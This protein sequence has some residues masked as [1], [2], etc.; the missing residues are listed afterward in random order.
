MTRH[1]VGALKAK[2]EK[3]AGAYADAAAAGSLE[4][5]PGF[6]IGE[7]TLDYFARE[8]LVE[9]MKVFSG[10]LHILS[11]V[12]ETVGRQVHAPT[13]DT[14]V[15]ALNLSETL[16]GLP[17]PV[18]Q[19]DHELYAALVDPA[20]LGALKAFQAQ[21]AVW[22]DA[23]R[24][25]TE[26]MLDPEAAVIRR[27]E[28]QAVVRLADEVRLKDKPLRELAAEAALLAAKA[29]R[30]EQTIAFGRRLARAFMVDTPMKA[31]V[32]RKLLNAADLAASLSQDLRPLRHPGLFDQAASR[33]LREG[34][35]R[36]QELQSELTPLS[37]RLKFEFIGQSHE[38]RGHT[39]A[40]R[41]AG[42]FSS[43]W[44]SDAW[45][46]KRRYKSM[47][48]VPGKVKPRAVVADF[49]ALAE[50]AE[51]IGGLAND[52]NLQAVCGPHF[53]G[54]ETPFERLIEVN[55]YATLVRQAYA[56]PDKIDL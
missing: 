50:C 26:S 17:E 8:R 7:S 30:V 34:R 11:G 20:A 27:A 3:L 24:E 21:Q 14:I 53:R 56:A 49:D 25:M 46:A 35:A 16:T 23:G 36:A 15:D 5:H 47:M 1:D 31:I 44:R 40:L 55:D 38:W 51:L 12:L 32:V 13:S 2:L 37:E 54:H 18:P 6:G 39:Q 42:L 29:D 48:R 4:K 19:I 9:D 43:L 10:A 41:T 45:A 33:L 52:A 28:L 22:L